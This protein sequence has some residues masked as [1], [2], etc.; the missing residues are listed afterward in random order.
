MSQAV[1]ESFTS[2]VI[3]LVLVETKLM[4]NSTVYL[5]TTISIHTVISHASQLLGMI[6][7]FET[8]VVLET[9]QVTD[10]CYCYSDQADLWKESLPE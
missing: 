1:I 10:I 9:A 5:P 4:A 8:F 6:R 7:P 2:A 3:C